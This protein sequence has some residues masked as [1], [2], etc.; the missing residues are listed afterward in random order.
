MGNTYVTDEQGVVKHWKKIAGRAV[1]HRE[2]GPAVIGP[3]G[4]AWYIN[5][6]RH[7]TDGPALEF[8]DGMQHW[9]LNGKLHRVDGPAITDVSAS[10][11]TPWYYVNG[12]WCPGRASYE[13]VAA[14]WLSYREVTRD[15][16]TSLIGNF[17]IVEWE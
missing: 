10:V 4:T 1:L 8:P 7:R 6:Q 2:D 12:I 5:G 11:A 13:K 17:R 16:I 15:E 3:W 14:V 9:C